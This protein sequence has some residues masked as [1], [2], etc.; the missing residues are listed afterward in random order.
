MDNQKY[1]G[2]VEREAYSD[3]ELY[4]QAF[5]CLLGCKSI[6]T[7]TAFSS[8]FKE[9]LETIKTH[10]ALIDHLRQIYRWKYSLLNSEP[11]ESGKQL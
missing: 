9:E 6:T 1:I 10:P 2:T 7:L 8:L 3:I 5:D 11:S 4:N